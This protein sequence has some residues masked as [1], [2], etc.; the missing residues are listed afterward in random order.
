MLPNQLLQL[1]ASVW[2]GPALCSFAGIYVSQSAASYSAGASTW[3]VSYT[4][5]TV[6]GQARQEF[7]GTGACPFHALRQALRALR[8]VAPGYAFAAVWQ[9]MKAE[10]DYAGLPAHA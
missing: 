9:V 6:P 2:R 3:Y 8:A 4:L 10:D 5:A 7:S 1:A